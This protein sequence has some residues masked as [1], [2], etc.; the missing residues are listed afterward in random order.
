MFVAF[1]QGSGT[2]QAI[3]LL[4]IEAIA[5]ISASVLKPWMDK[6]SN[7]LGISICAIN[8]L[9]AIFLLIMTDIFSGPGLLIGVVSVIFFILNAAFALVLLI[10]V[11]IVAIKSFF[12]KNPEMRYLGMADNRSSFIK[13][14]TGLT[15]SNELD[16]LAFTARGGE[17]KGS[18]METHSLENDRLSDPSFRKSETTHSHSSYQEPLNSPAN[19]SIPFMPRTDSPLYHDGAS[20]SRPVSPISNAGSRHSNVTAHRTQNASG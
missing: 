12:R 5:L 15:P 16:D 3:A 6:S 2:T 11:L 9:N 4:L 13:S 14:S 10:I 19:P 7:I 20:I 18:F 1:G 8:F 17:G